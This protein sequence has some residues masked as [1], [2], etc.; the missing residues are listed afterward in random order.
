MQNI[1]LEKA[2]MLGISDAEYLTDKQLETEVMYASLNKEGRQVLAGRLG[3][4]AECIR[5]VLPEP[6]VVSRNRE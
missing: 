5:T 3:R 2:R 1:L 6:M 4:Y